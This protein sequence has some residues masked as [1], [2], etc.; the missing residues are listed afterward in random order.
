V[1]NFSKKMEVKK[2][3]PILTHAEEAMVVATIQEVEN[4][5]SGEVRVFIEEF[6]PDSPL[7]RV[8][9]LFLKNK[10]HETRHRNGVLIYLAHG[11]RELA[12]W[13][14]EGIHE[15]VG[16]DFWTLEREV[17][18]THF[19]AKQY[20]EGLCK[21][22]QQVGDR[23]SAHFPHEADDKNELPDTIIYG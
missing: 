22:I 9:A 18:R 1:A 5:S 14:D 20:A 19:R 21:V 10:M 8:A 6:C 11:T 15:I 4:R 7:E 2:P 3:H 13:G 23:L 12:I 16:A 17:L